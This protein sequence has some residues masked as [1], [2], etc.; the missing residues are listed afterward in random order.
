MHPVASVTVKK[1][2]FPLMALF[3]NV[4]IGLANDDEVPSLKYHS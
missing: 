3:I 4:C 1:A 2:Q